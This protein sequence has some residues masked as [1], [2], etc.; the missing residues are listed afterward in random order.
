[1]RRIIFVL[2]I[3]LSSCFSSGD[4]T[5]GL[6]PRPAD[7]QGPSIIWN[8]FEKPLP[9]I[10][11]PNNI[12]TRFDDD[13]PTKLRLNISEEAVTAH[14]SK[15]RRLINTLDGFGNFAPIW[16]SFDGLLEI[17]DIYERHSNTDFSDD[18][19]YL[20]NLN[21]ESDNFGQPVF[22]DMGNGRFPA[23]IETNDNY[24]QNDPRD[25]SSNLLFETE[26]EDLN[27]NGQLDYF[28]DTDGDGT[29]DKPNLWGRY[30]NDP[31]RM[32]RYN[33]LITFY[34]F[35]TNTLI[36]RPVFALEPES[37]YAVV[38]TRRVKGAESDSPVRSPFPY[39]NHMAQSVALKPLVDAHMLSGLGLEVDD[40]AFAWSFTT[41]SVTRDLEALRAGLYGEGDFDF[42][43][44]DFPARIA[45]VAPFD[46]PEHASNIYTLDAARFMDVL[47]HDGFRAAAG[48]GSSEV[49]ISQANYLEFV[50]YLVGFT[51]DSPALIENDDGVFR[52]NSMTG[53]VDYTRESIQV[54]CVV[55][56]ESESHKAPFPITFYG[57]GY[58]STRLEMLGFAPNLARFGLASCAIDSYGHGVEDSEENKATTIGLLG[59]AG[60]LGLA[61]FVLSGRAR[62]LNADGVTDAGGDFWTANTFHTRDVVRQ[63][64]L[65]YMQVIR[66]MRSFGQETMPVDV[67]GSGSDEVAG[68]FNGDGVP[69][70]GGEQSYTYFGQ[71]LGG[72]IAM[73]LG[74]IEPAV[75]ATA[76]SAGGAG[77]ADI[78]V[79]SRQGGVVQAVFLP[80][81]GPIIVATPGDEGELD[82]AFDALNINYEVLLPFAEVDLS[83]PSE[84]IKVG[85]VVQVANLDNGEVD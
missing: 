62:D 17:E 6:A 12:A 40:V 55:P 36:F 39:V 16:L 58:T 77:L 21:P 31:E 19:V 80:L 54:M 43:G 9:E 69:D 25:N 64:I 84:V 66:V 8:V 2:P 47:G 1:M 34:E 45:E 70:M 15:L 68:D 57:H 20:V 48:V 85:D 65:D 44:E 18:A 60:L 22:L 27:G 23:T 3:L 74:S 82:I 29:L 52:M 7:D 51:V 59:G 32:D 42:L 63:T 67:D 41:Q 14:E 72:I 81:L 24:F 79:R 73:V 30:L 46:S 78:A 35:E 83:D 38:I 61:D 11:F 53:E 50:D 76:P 49:E 4:P 37:T 75:V 5:A 13:S 26:D 33:D 56:K 71:S 10:P 28:E